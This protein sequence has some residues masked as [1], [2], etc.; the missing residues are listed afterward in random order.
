MDDIP[1]HANDKNKAFMT[2]FLVAILEK[3]YAFFK[4]LT[5]L[6]VFILILVDY[7][8]NKSIFH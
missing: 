8:F 1:K 2:N 6:Q 4:T 3:K 5:F 7:C